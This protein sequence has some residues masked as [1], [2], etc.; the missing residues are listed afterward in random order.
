MPRGGRREGA[1]RPVGAKNGTRK[2]KSKFRCEE[3]FNCTDCAAP[4]SAKRASSH[5]TCNACA[6]RRRGRLICQSLWIEHDCRYCGIRYSAS[7][8]MV[9]CDDTCRLAANN[10]KRYAI[11]RADEAP[12]GEPISLMVLR[13]SGWKCAVCGVDTPDHLRGSM[14]LN[15]PEVD[16]IVPLSRGG[17]HE[18]GNLQCLCKRCNLSK[19]SKLMSEWL[20][21]NDNN[22]PPV[23]EAA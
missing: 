7:A 15:S 12:T 22:T 20:P 14:R 4:I 23:R 5:G 18:Y 13:A 19:G 6:S 8:K 16:H 21:A 17:L 2:K 1:G 9:Y 3:C 11:R 10:E